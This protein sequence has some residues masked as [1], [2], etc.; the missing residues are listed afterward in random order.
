MKF[1]LEKAIS[2]QPVVLRNGAK[3]FVRYYETEMDIGYSLWGYTEKDHRYN[4]IT[5][6]KDGHFHLISTTTET[7]EDIVG[8]WIEPAVFNHWDALD[9]KWKYIAADENGEVCV[10]TIEPMK[11][12]DF[13]AIVLDASVGF[14]KVTDLLKFEYTNW[15]HSLTVRPQ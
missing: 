11:Y 5:W 12:N 8:M 7:P 10:F 3:A 4:P 6:S 15:E 13:W 14:M 9:P 2:G 1:D